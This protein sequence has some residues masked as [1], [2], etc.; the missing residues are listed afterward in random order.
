MSTLIQNI[1]GSILMELIPD[2]VIE[3]TR[4]N[5][6]QQDKD[7]INKQLDMICGGFE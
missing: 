3:V 6:T 2:I 4:I 1:S 7:I 5:P